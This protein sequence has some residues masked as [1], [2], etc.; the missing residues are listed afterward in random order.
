MEDLRGG[1]IQDD[2][3]E[4]YLLNWQ[5]SKRNEKTFHLDDTLA[6]QLKTIEKPLTWLVITEAWCG[7]S[8][9]S[10]AGLHHIAEASNGKIRLKIFYRDEDTTLI[11][12]FLTNGGRSIPKLIQLDEHLHV[13]GTWGPRPKAAQELVVRLKSDPATA[14]TY[15]EGLHKW[16]ADDKMRSLQAEITDLLQVL[17]K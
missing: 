15:S 13:T 5:R 7:D 2:K 11:D 6:A 1:A 8:A 12:A 4:Y 3:S 16:Y 14:A 17:T 9:Q 10:L